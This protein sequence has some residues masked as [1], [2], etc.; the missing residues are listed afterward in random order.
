MVDAG[1]PYAY[2][3][4]N[5][6]R[7]GPVGGSP[8]SPPGN[9]SNYV[10]SDHSIMELDQ[11]NHMAISEDGPQDIHGASNYVVPIHGADGTPAFYIWVLDSSDDNC[12]GQTGWGCVYPDQ[13]EWFRNKA[14]ELRKRDGRV[15]PGIAFLH[16]PLAE[17]LEVWDRGED[18]NGTKGEAVCCSSVNTGL[19]AAMAEAGNIQGAFS[20]HDHGN[21]FVG[22]K[23]GILIGYGRKSGYG[24][25]INGY[26]PINGGVGARMIELSEHAGNVQWRT[27][28]RTDSG[29]LIDQRPALPLKYREL[30]S[31]GTCGGAS[32]A[33][34]AETAAS[35]C[36]FD[37]SRKACRTAVGLPEEV[38]LIV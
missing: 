37:G 3:L 9:E 11:T 14:K 30:T 28:I 15:V 32:Q 33:A 5:H 35:I 17:V 6:D 21:D 24:G 12:V 25:Y 8:A 2:A 29:K 16:I 36:K 34:I 31:Q 1:V 23:D 20:G 13:V 26:I 38:E 27:Y 18:V 22:R 4:G 10:V 7:I 19:F